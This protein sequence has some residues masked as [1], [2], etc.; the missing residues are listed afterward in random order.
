LRH[1]SNHLIEAVNARLDT[2]FEQIHRWRARIPSFTDAFF[3][4]VGSGLLAVEGLNR[5]SRL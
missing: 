5:I 4:S 3:I 1:F 2:N